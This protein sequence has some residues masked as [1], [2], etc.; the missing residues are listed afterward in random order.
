MGGGGGATGGARGGGARG[1]ARGG[2]SGGGLSDGRGEPAVEFDGESGGVIGGNG[3]EMEDLDG[4]PGETIE[5]RS[6][7]LRFEGEDVEPRRSLDSGDPAEMEALPPPCMWLCMKC[8]LQKRMPSS[9]PQTS[10]GLSFLLHVA[11]R[12]QSMCITIF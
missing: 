8:A 9:C 6:I 7:E 10:T 1:G 11:Q 3:I 5:P 2:E 4:E 12:M